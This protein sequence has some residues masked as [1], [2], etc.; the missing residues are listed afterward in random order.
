M[1]REK[2]GV[3]KDIAA[4]TG[5]EVYIGVVGPVRTG[6]STFIKK[7]ME[8]LVLPVIDNIGVKNRATDELPQ[9]AAGRTIMTTEPKFVPEEAISI[10]LDDGAV[11]RMRLIDCVGYMVRGA[12]GHTEDEAPRM[13]RSP[14]YEEEVPFDVAAET[15]TRK[16]ITEHS[17]V[18]VVITTDGT[19]SDI[20]RSEY[21]PAE[22]RVIAELK[23]INKPF[24]VLLNCV[25]PKSA[26]SE[27][28]AAD[29][30]KLYDVPVMPVNCLD[31]NE[32]ALRGIIDTLTREF[33]VG[34][35]DTGLPGW[36]CAL[37]KGH[38]LRDSV[39]EAVRNYAA[40]VVRMRDINEKADILL[41]NEHIACARRLSADLGAGEA[42]LA[43]ALTP[44]L[45]YRIL[46]ETTGLD[47]R[48][49]ASLMPSIIS[50]CEIKAKYEK[51]KGA[52]DQVEATGYGI[53]MP[54]LDELTLEEP[55]IVKQG[56]KYGV[57]LRASA[58]SVHMLR[59]TITTE[60]SP[61]VGS[62]KQ[63][64]ELVVSL[65]REFEEDPIKIWQS[66]IFGKSLNE[67]VNE[68]LQ[69]K[70]YHMPA[71]ARLRLQETLERVIN[72]G[73][74]GLVCIIL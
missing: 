69:N 10:D 40:A 70:L 64:E 18:G 14:W 52:L 44:D 37:P 62:E 31:L 50:L 12:L 7:F 58:P 66:N 29:L 34:L 46:G 72:D 2:L 22:Q 54:S 67:L 53:V 27:A 26:E 60:V 23:E 68:G 71:A 19:I 41:E 33:P 51:I 3:Y 63:S 25:D 43:L 55:E 11:L 45:F 15:G 36:L 8:E 6:K 73:C 74:S 47:I 17:T 38:W 4:R 9:S 28:L 13:V 57:K 48:D 49:E 20:P 61:I 39:F 16:V 5:G 59:A 32:E 21:E 35:I 42:T 56:G 30:S 24:I 1:D 65:L